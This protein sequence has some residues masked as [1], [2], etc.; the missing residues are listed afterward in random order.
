[1]E[2]LSQDCFVVFVRDQSGSIREPETLERPI[3][4]CPSYGEAVKARQRLRQPGQSCIIR[5]VSETGGGD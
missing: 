5:C 3:A 2:I 4:T 1:M